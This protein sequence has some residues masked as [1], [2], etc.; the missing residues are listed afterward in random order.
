MNKGDKQSR[1]YK[2]ES[3]T[4][5]KAKTSNRPEIVHLSLECSQCSAAIPEFIDTLPTIDLKKALCLDCFVKQFGGEYAQRLRA[6][7]EEVQAHYA[8]CTD[9]L[10][11]HWKEQAEWSKQEQALSADLNACTADNEEGAETRKDLQ[12][13]LQTARWH[14][15][16]ARTSAQ[17]EQRAQQKH[18]ESFWKVIQDAVSTYR[19][20][21][22]QLETL[23]AR[24]RAAQVL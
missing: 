7:L 23:R 21:Q 14:L 12:T 19:A 24:A 3:K 16:E 9:V 6:R 20:Q 5:K 4:S 10:K 2:R 22:Q 13:R 15:S 8:A 1:A 11:D 18:L 17:H